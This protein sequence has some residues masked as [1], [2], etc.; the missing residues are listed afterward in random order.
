MKKYCLKNFQIFVKMTKIWI[1]TNFWARSNFNSFTNSDLPMTNDG[2]LKS[3]DQGEF[4]LGHLAEGRNNYKNK[5]LV[6]SKQTVCCTPYIILQYSFY[7][8][9]LLNSAIFKQNQLTLVALSALAQSNQKQWLS[10]Q[11]SSQYE[12]F[13]L[14]VVPE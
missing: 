10:S 3:W 5:L 7:V 2:T 12:A 9:A 8:K 6:Q 1:N 13:F 14:K 4:V 11:P